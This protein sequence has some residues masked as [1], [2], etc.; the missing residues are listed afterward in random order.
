MYATSGGYVDEVPMQEIMRIGGAMQTQ[1]VFGD[2][3]WIV[4]I[5]DQI[6]MYWW[7]QFIILSYSILFY[8]K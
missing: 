8:S 6:W 2:L 5:R 1:I 4:D 3:V 7:L